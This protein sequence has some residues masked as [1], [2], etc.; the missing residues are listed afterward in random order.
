MPLTWRATTACARL[1]SASVARGQAASRQFALCPPLGLKSARSK[2]LRRSRTTDAARRS[3]V[4]YRRTFE[5]FVASRTSYIARSERTTRDEEVDLVQEDRFARPVNWTQ[6]EE[7]KQTWHVI[8]MQCVV[9]A[10]ARV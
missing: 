8:K 2:T 4:A 5:I 3:G 10:A 7:E 1:R 6:T 9:F